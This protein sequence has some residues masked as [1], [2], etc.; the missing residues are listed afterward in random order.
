M[1]I[2]KFLE[3]TI[4]CQFHHDKDFVRA[5]QDL[6]NSH[7]V[8]IVQC[9]KHF[10]FLAHQVNNVIAF[11]LDIRFF[12]DFHRTLNLSCLMHCNIDFTIVAFTNHILL[13]IHIIKFCTRA[14]EM[15][16]IKFFGINQPRG[17]IF[18][19]LRRHRR[20]IVQIERPSIKNRLLLRLIA[21][22]LRLGVLTQISH[23]L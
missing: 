19:L 12:H 5:F 21:G 15:E 6:Q 4:F 20:N 22:A 16:I 10:K 3:L 14:N 23:F 2:Q 8:L 17:L 11:F 9:F 1:L 7:N 13:I 18:Q